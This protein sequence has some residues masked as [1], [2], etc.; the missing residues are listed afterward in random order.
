MVDTVRQLEAEEVVEK[1]YDASDPK[2][3]NEARKKEGRLKRTER[4]LTQAMMSHVNGR[5]FLYNLVKCVVEGDP[6]SIGDP[7]ATYYN[8]GQERKARE[9]FK[10][11]IKIDP[12][13][14]T[15]MLQENMPS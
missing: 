5:F 3:V 2:Q 15:E 8:L 9:L 10:E 7:H 6:L 14:F 11:M 4:E 1:A 12:E 13:G